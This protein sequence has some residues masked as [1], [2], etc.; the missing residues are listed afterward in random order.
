MQPHRRRQDLT[1]VVTRTLLPQPGPWVLVHKAAARWHRGDPRKEQ[2]VPCEHAED[3]LGP[4]QQKSWHTRRRLELR[5][6]S[7]AARLQD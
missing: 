4:V 5:P 3:N 7:P 2:V 6:W 1:I